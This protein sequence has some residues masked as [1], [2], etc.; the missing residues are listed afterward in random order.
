MAA[1]FVLRAGGCDYGDDGSMEPDQRLFHDF[2]QPFCHG[3]R[4]GAYTVR[5]RD[6]ELCRADADMV[7]REY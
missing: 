6:H 3:I 2:C 4:R 7:Q 5:R 1:H